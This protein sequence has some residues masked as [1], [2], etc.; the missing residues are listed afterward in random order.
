MPLKIYLLGQFKLLANDTP[1]DLPS[2]PAQSLLAFLALNAGTV[3]RREKLASMLWPDTT[4]SNARSYLRQALWRIRKAFEAHSLPCEDFLDITDILM[5]FKH[6][7]DHWLDVD[8]V[9][10]T[11]K[12]QSIEQIA[13]NLQ[14]YQGELLP[15]F[16]DEWILPERERLQAAFHQ[17]MTLLLDKLTDAKKWNEAIDWSEH[18]IRHGF[19]PESAFR[20]LM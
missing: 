13:E 7:S 19:T 8:A 4:E 3:Q 10:K 12:D 11:T 18:W 14:H 17:K 5:T 16:Y 6:Q 15:G 9:L 2:R 1:F 20:A